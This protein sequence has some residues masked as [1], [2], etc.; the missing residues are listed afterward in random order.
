MTKAT[1]DDLKEVP[2]FA[3]LENRQLRRLAKH[4]RER[5]VKAGTVVV[6]EGE[7]SGVGFFVIADGEAVV[8]VGGSDV[9]TVGAGDHFGELA[10]VSEGR[11][12][13]TVTART[14]LELWEIPFWEFREFAHANPDVTWKL[15]QHVVGLIEPAG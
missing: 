9:K 5:S 11:R 3:G 14:D 10:L 7:M 8:N 13:A 15:L 2:L 6:R 1:P 4:F 12:S